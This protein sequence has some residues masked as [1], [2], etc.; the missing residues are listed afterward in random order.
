MK[1]LGLEFKDNLPY[2]IALEQLVKIYSVDTFFSKFSEESES[3]VF[4]I[5]EIRII[6]GTIIQKVLRCKNYS[7]E[8]S[9]NNILLLSL[10]ITSPYKV[11]DKNQRQQNETVEK[12]RELGF[13]QDEIMREPMLVSH[14]SELDETTGGS[15]RDSMALGRDTMGNTVLMN[16]K[17]QE[18]SKVRF[19]EGLYISLEQL[20]LVKKQFTSYIKDHI[21]KNQI[22]LIFST[23]TIPSSLFEELKEAGVVVIFPVTENEMKLLSLVLKAKI[24]NNISLLTQELGSEYLGNIKSYYLANLFDPDTDAYHT[25]LVFL[26]RLEPITNEL[27]SSLG[28]AIYSSDKNKNII[29]KNFLRENL[30]YIYFSL[31]E[32]E[33]ILREKEST[34][35]LYSDVEINFSLVGDFRSHLIYSV[36][37][38]RQLIKNASSTLQFTVVELEPINNENCY[39]DISSDF[40]SILEK[41]FA[42]IFGMEGLRSVHDITNRIIKSIVEPQEFDN[43][44]YLFNTELDYLASLN[45]SKNDSFMV[46]TNT[47]QKFEH[48]PYSE[49]DMTLSKYLNKQFNEYDQFENFH[50]QK[51]NNKQSLIYISNSCIKVK[52]ESLK[53]ELNS[54]FFLK[55][56][57]ALSKRQQFESGLRIFHLF[58]MQSNESFDRRASIQSTNAK[59]TSSRIPRLNTM[60]GSDRF[61]LRDSNMPNS[62]KL[63]HMNRA[64]KNMKQ[65]RF[66]NPPTANR[67][68]I[69][70]L[71]VEGNAKSL[72]QSCVMC[73][74]CGRKLSDPMFLDSIHKNMSL[75]LYLFSFTQQKKN[76]DQLKRQNSEKNLDDIEINDNL[77]ID[78][79]CNHSQQARAFIQGNRLIKLIRYDVTMHKLIHFKQRDYLMGNNQL[80]NDTKKSYLLQKLKLEDKVAKEIGEYL[81]K[82]VSLLVYV[83][84]DLIIK[85]NKLLSNERFQKNHQKFAIHLKIIKFFSRFCDIVNKTWF[86]MNNFQNIE[87]GF[88]FNHLLRGIM[89]SYKTFDHALSD[90]HSLVSKI[91]I[92]AADRKA[93]IYHEVIVAICR[94][95]KEYTNFSQKAQVNRPRLESVTSK[96]REITPARESLM[97]EREDTNLLLRATSAVRNQNTLRRANTET[98]LDETE[99]DIN[100][101]EKQDKPF[102]MKEEKE[103]VLAPSR[104]TKKTATYL[105]NHTTR[106]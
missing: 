47:P 77:G 79:F 8:A 71:T 54:V 102:E 95:D 57:L 38:L 59:S 105:M 21:R 104:D 65:I 101:N 61:R 26:D 35:K 56:M 67:E 62:P 64:S 13:N 36:K 10:P 76:R 30:V 94:I 27:Y 43:F 19:P 7:V 45:T 74:I 75:M 82:Q 15:R 58:R 88:R 41:F 4:S 60:A 84:R 16:S 1:L 50:K 66:S 69:A 18:K 63:G 53:K 46:I 81:I 51:W 93:I 70:P 5:G 29:L 17:I 87:L 22:E 12:V 20:A 23:E 28:V 37:N 52:V 86:V 14:V 48:S 91:T 100:P 78:N 6:N 55:N 42:K 33:L 106:S 90:L 9:I 96:D 44:Y 11:L 83:L 97:P 31:T 32:H 72:I 2:N 99:L 85:G 80:I 25:S 73:D 68:N 40:N 34:I 98:N 24:I 49:Q 89:L 39:P 3:D 103:S 92:K